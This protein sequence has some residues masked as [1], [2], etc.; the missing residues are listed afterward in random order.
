MKK[1]LNKKQS[2]LVT[3]SFLETEVLAK[4]LA[5]FLEPGTVICLFGDLGAG[6]T[7]F[8]RGIASALGCDPEI[9]T[10][11]TFT[12]LNIYQGEHQI[13]HF[14]LYRLKDVEEFMGMGFE[15]YLGDD[16][17]TCVEWSERIESLLEELPVLE[18][19]IKHLGENKREF[20]FYGSWPDAL[21][22]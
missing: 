5:P 10:S 8:I 3:G 13:Y 15:T 19:H 21:S 6:K 4:K 7:T 11:P 18:I 20:Q 1:G 22:F 17:I 12:Y 14:D 16:A 9:V 2:S